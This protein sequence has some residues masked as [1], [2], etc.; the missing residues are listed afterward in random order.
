MQK[1]K[2]LLP[3]LL[4]VDC[5]K[6]ILQ[7]FKRSYCNLKVTLKTTSNATSHEKKPDIIKNASILGYIC[8]FVGLLNLLGLQTINIVA[9]LIFFC[10]AICMFAYCYMQS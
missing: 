3:P 10:I 1:L 9:A 2:L 8:T 7:S 6:I 5:V 4:L